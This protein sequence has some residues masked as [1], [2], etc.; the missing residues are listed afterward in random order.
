MRALV[1]DAWLLASA[2]LGLIGFASGS[3]PIVLLAALIFGTGGIARLWARLSLEQ[4]VYRRAL[5]EHRV[6]VGESVE[7]R[8]ILENR[9]ALPVPWLEL[10]ETLPR[11]MPTRRVRTAPEIGRAHV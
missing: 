3:V 2:L 11:G 8:L 7:A 1:G 4:V 10:R 6:F 5:S 9:K